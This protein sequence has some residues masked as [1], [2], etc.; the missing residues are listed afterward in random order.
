MSAFSMLP[1][2]DAAWC[3]GAFFASWCFYKFAVALI[4]AWG[5]AVKACF[6]VGLP[7]LASQLG[8]TLPKTEAERRRF[9]QSY[10]QALIYRTEP[11]YT[12]MFSPEDWLPKEPESL[13]RRVMRLLRIAL[14]RD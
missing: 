14:A 6:D 11:D 12:P 2:S 9:W 10:S 3:I 7:A 13:L 4:P 5:E 8:F 1:R